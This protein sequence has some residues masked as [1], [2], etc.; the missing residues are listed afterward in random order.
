MTA[1]KGF[2]IDRFLFNS[3]INKALSE[4]W[5]AQELW[6]I[7]YLLK[8]TISSK[9]RAYIGETTDPLN[10]FYQHISHP[11]KKLL[12]E[13][14]LITSNK[15]NKSATRN[16]ESNLIK[17][18][19]GDASYELL[20]V[21]LGLD[22]HNYFQKDEV[23][24]PIFRSVW[25]QLRKR[26]ITQHTL[27]SIDNSDLFKYSP[28]KT[29]SPDQTEILLVVLHSLLDI[30]YRNVFIEG[31]AGTGKSVLAVF[32]F[33]LLNTPKEDF[34]YVD[35]GAS[36]KEIFSLISK[37]KE[38]YPSPKMALIIPMTSFRKT[39]KTIFSHVQGLKPNM[40]IGP[41]DLVRQH[42][43]IV[44]V[45]ESHRLRQRVN[46]GSYVDFDK[47]TARLGLNNMLH[48]ELDWVIKQSDKT[49]L[50]YD[51][52]Q[53]IK[54]SDTA[55]EAFDRLKDQPQTQTKFLNSQFRVRGGIKYVNFIRQLLSAT[56]PKDREKVSFKG[57]D[58]FLFPDLQ[59][60]IK[61]IKEKNQQYKL[62]RVVAG[63]AWPWVSRKNSKA[64]D[65]QIQALQLKWNSVNRD[66]INSANAINEI[67]C[68]HTTQGYDLNYTGIIFGP[69]IGYDKQ[70]QEIIIHK[71]NYHD[72][73]GKNNIKKPEQLKNYI[74][75]IY[76]TLMLRG[77]RGTYLFVCDEGLREYFAQY[78]PSIEDAAPRNVHSQK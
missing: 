55:K 77:I 10:R 35:F 8:E 41:A 60:L 12:S 73:N 19:S 78:I 53:S 28:Y 67:G 47:V 59:E 38:K 18:L 61:Q 64:F 16:L 22:N 33:K 6:P 46:L 50:F 1:G 7:V 39:V 40:V 75:H 56:V 31:G 66:W 44:L 32:L 71:E 72:R 11:E 25:D 58:F 4:Y 34:S 52:D 14:Y 48:S 37:L 24:A 65:I 29:L 5:Y 2:K 76:K 42:Y 62:A 15:F 45:D 36:D 51:E 20:N 23:Y 30:K 21:N 9:K 17:Y 57:Y 70:K 69:E 27:A 13:A 49:I 63:Y 54:P 68:I 26:G 43:D 3:T 74:L